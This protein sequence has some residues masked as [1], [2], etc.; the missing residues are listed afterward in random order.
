[1]R[2]GSLIHCSLLLYEPMFGHLFKI[3]F[4]Y[5]WL[6]VGVRPASLLN[7]IVRGEKIFKALGHSINDDLQILNWGVSVF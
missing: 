6:L 3:L 5:G 1:M 2:I 7:S 4:V